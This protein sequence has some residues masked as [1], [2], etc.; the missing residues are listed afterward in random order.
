M[1]VLRAL[2]FLLCLLAEYIGDRCGV[3][4]DFCKMYVF[5]S[6]FI[7]YIRVELYLSVIVVS[8]WMCVLHSFCRIRLSQ[9]SKGFTL[10][11]D[12]K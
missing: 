8:Y 12:V 5:V 1:M 2:L 3:R 7:C 10:S 11:E 9:N 6:C 4:H